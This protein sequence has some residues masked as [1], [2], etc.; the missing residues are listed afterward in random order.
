MLA[1]VACKK[2]E[3]KDEAPAT[4]DTATKPAAEPTEKPT[5]EPA[6]ADGEKPDAMAAIDGMIADCATTAEAR[7]ARHAEKPL[8]E[9]LGG[10]EPLLAFTKRVLER[11]QENPP[12]Q[13]LFDG[14]DLDKLANHF[15]DFVGAG[16]GGPEKYTGRGMKELHHPMNLTAEQVLAA[17]GDIMATLAEFKIPKDES[18]EVMCIILSFKDDLIA[19]K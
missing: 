2:D 5:P 12:I 16:T 10:R 3:K 18:E 14:P 19:A 13:A 17:G 7:A 4:T 11:H 15:V 1:T 9:R 6:V 8:Y